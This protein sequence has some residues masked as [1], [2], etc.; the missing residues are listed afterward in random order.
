MSTFRSVSEAKS[1]L[2]VTGSKES[3]IED[4]NTNIELIKARIKK[5][6]KIT[7]LTVGKY[8]KTRVSIIYIS[9]IASKSLVKNISDKIK[10]TNIDGIIDSSYLKRS[11]DD[12]F[13][14]FP[15]IMSTERPDKTV[16]GLL[17]GK[18]VVMIDNSPYAL[19]LPTFLI[20]YFH[21]SDDYYQK[22][23]NTTF[24][25]IIR[26]IA[27]LVGIFL[28]G[29]F[30]AFTTRNYNLVPFSLLLMLK[31]GRT[32]VPF[33]AYV[34]A[35]IMII[36]FE[37]LR[38]S[39]IR[40]S[41]T[42]ASSISILG[43]LIL[44]DAAVA[45]GIVSPIMI[46]IIAMSSIAGLVFNSLEFVNT[47]RIY[48][49]INLVLGSLFGIIGIGLGFILLLFNILYTKSFG[50]DYFLHSTEFNDSIIR[51]N[52]RILKRNKYLTNNVIRGRYRWRRLS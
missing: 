17:E 49:I 4:I 31:A 13:N 43:G 22:S 16:M 19:I 30:I 52:K 39:D 38:E 7:H 32:F 20:D 37:I 45:A 42:S 1:E 24:I 27:F 8:T 25:R 40:M 10:S 50:Y 36:C 28:P 18:V 11:L 33:P 12:G 34:E 23:Y 5:D 46:I 14:L 35:I 9:S 26:L 29:A 41:S 51:Y 15:S 6:L 47:I 48:K 21:T 2:S 3:F 44:G